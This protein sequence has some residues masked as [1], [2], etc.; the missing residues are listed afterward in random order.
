MGGGNVGTTSRSSDR[1]LPWDQRASESLDQLTRSLAAWARVVVEQRRTHG[2]PACEGMCQ[3][4]SCWQV[5]RL[6]PPA[7][8]APSLATF[9]L[10]HVDWLRRHIFAELIVTQIVDAT[11]K[12]G[13]VIDRRPDLRYAGPCGKPLDDDPNG[14][15]CTEDLYALRK[16]KHVTCRACG[17]KTET[18]PRFAWLVETARDQLATASVLADALADLL[19]QKITSSMVRSY[20]FRGR[21]LERGLTRDGYPLYRV[22]DLEDLL[23]EDAQRKAR[24]EAKR[25]QRKGQRRTAC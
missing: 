22:G 25:E 14:A 4:R 5:S 18:E 2:G 20:A 23:I 16:A 3:H 10:G 7:N 17:E 15:R 11:A 13:H 24:A 9:L 12:V 1:P 19:G 6:T 21:L 8:K